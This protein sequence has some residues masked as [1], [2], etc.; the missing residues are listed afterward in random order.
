MEDEKC[1]VSKLFKLVFSNNIE[2]LDVT[3]IAL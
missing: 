2:T 3:H 1:T